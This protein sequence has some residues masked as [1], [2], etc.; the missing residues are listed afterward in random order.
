LSYCGGLSRLPVAAV[1]RRVYSP[2]T[3]F[4]HRSMA[5]PAKVIPA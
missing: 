2:A 3:A 5:V 4:S 1:R